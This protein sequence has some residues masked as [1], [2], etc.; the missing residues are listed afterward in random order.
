MIRRWRFVILVSV[1]S[2]T[3]LQEFALKTVYKGAVDFAAL[4]PQ[5]VCCAW[6]CHVGFHSHD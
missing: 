5:A 4:R 3:S 1:A 2:L 6:A